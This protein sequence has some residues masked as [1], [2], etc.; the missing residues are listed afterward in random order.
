MVINSRIFLRRRTG[1]CGFAHR[2]QPHRTGQ[3]CGGDRRNTERAHQLGI[4]HYLKSRRENTYIEI[5]S[6]IAMYSAA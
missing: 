4:R 1:I 3:K 5:E 2:L 6:S